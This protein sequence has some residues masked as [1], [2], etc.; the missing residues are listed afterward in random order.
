MDIVDRHF[1][2]E[3]AHDVEAT[4]AT[5]TD[6]IIWDDVT[7]PDS[8]VHGK[9]AVGAVYA[10]IQEAIPDLHLETVR[11]LN[12]PD[13]AFV[14]DESILTGHVRGFWAGVAGGGA[15]VRL[16]MLHVFNLRDGLIERENTWFDSA[17]VVRQI[18]AA[19]AS[20]AAAPSD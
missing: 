8:P 16:R 1:A 14:V 18:E 17:D 9:A 13:G 12:S 10:G 3:N 11:R 20:G 19:K 2:A 15:P 6:N 7:H 4:L 5:Y